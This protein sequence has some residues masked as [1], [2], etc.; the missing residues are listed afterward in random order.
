MLQRF[1]DPLAV[2]LL[3]GTLVLASVAG[4]RESDT[5]IT[6]AP[7]SGPVTQTQ[8]LNPFSHVALIPANADLKSIQFEKI[9]PV[10]VPTAIRY[11]MDAHQCELISSPDPG[12]SVAC[13]Y[14]ETE[15]PVPAYEAT[16]SYSGEPLASDE[17]ANRKFTFAVYFR[18]EDVPADVQQ[19]IAAKKLS[20]T[21]RA[22]YFAVTTSQPAV[23][24][25]AIDNTR[26]RFCSGSYVDGLWTHSDSAC[27]DSIAYSSQTTPSPYVTVQIDTT[28]PQRA[29]R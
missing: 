19:A 24:T 1:F 28:A 13:P 12:G 2:A 18:P 6:A 7:G 21:D 5:V 26:S 16:Y 14:V 29:G 15:A 25:V 17:Q 11:T 3:S 27:R 9:R 23:T 20:R 4:A 8:N 22:A 10:T